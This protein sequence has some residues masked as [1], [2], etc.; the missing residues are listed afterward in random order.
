M[1]R[2]IKTWGIIFLVISLLSGCTHAISK[3]LRGQ[4]SPKVDFEAVFSNPLAH[5]GEIVLWG[6]TIIQSKNKKEGTLI[7]V[8]QNSLDIVGR[9][10][11]TDRTGGRFLALYDGVLD[12]A[13]YSKGREVTLAGEVKGKRVL[14]LGEIEYTYPLVSVKEIHLWPV[15]S[16]EAFYPYYP[17]GYY[18]YGRYYPHRRYWYY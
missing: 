14:P 1:K 7:E 15:I 11:D 8:L 3:R 10:K 16:T 9:P 5:K 12:V 18:P 2:K 17:Y 4:V 6:G 13:I